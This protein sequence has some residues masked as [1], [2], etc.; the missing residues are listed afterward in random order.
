MYPGSCIVDC[1]GHDLVVKKFNDAIPGLYALLVARTR[2]FDDEVV[3]AVSN[4]A[5]QLVIL[6]A[7]YCMRGYR[8]AL[9]SV[10]AFEVDQPLVQN[11]KKK[12]IA[13]LALGKRA[14]HVVHVPVDFTTSTLEEGL[15]KCE[16]FDPTKRT[17]FI[18]EGLTQYIPKEATAATLASIDK[19]SGPGSTLLVSYVD[20]RFFS[21]AAKCCG[22]GFPVA[23]AESMLPAVAKAGE[24][25]IAGFGAR[26]GFAQFL[27]ANSSFK[28]TMD[29][30][31]DELNERIYGPVGRSVPPAAMLLC[32]RFV[33]AAKPGYTPA[34]P[35]P[36]PAP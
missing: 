1:L 14:E 15:A 24:P 32:E 5:T 11:D 34:V 19:L 29:A 13:D 8:L 28:P 33:I 27:G 2:L 25:W 36:A 21:D 20:E 10:P 9:G 4:G 18:M 22:E 35:V 26:A 7:G 16:A 23:K 3:K 17:V 12:R 30:S 31:I 6:G